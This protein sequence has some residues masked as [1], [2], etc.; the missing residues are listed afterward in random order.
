MPDTQLQPESTEGFS[1]FINYFIPLLA[2]L[3]DD[4]SWSEK[5][6]LLCFILPRKCSDPILAK[7]TSLIK[8]SLKMSALLTDG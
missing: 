3:L 5:V 4:I 6:T 7:R 2:F 1:G 8:R